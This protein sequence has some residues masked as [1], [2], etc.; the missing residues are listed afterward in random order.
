MNGNNY[1]SGPKQTYQSIMSED[2][3]KK[4][5]QLEYLVRQNGNAAIA[6][7]FVAGLTVIFTVIWLYAFEKRKHAD[8]NPKAGYIMVKSDSVRHLSYTIDE[9][10]REIKELYRL[11][12]SLKNELSLVQADSTVT[13][14]Q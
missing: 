6:G 5:A 7:I 14:A 11:V 8:H 2:I 3:Y 1:I 13:E 12:D 10:N 9:Q 4:L